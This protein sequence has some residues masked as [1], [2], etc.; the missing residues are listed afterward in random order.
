LLTAEHIGF[1]PIAKQLETL[2]GRSVRGRLTAHKLL[3]SA[4]NV[5]LLPEPRRLHLLPE[6]PL[7]GRLT[8]SKGSLF[9]RL[10]GLKGLI[11]LLLEQ[12]GVKL[13]ERPSL[14]TTQ[15]TDASRPDSRRR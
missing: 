4:E 6:R 12:L 15:P 7:K 9:G 10:L 2:A 8:T 11:R 5:R 13:G 14:L 1:L 3:L